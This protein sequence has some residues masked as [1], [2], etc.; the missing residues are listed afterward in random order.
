M[1]Y[2]RSQN[3]V[4]SKFRNVGFPSGRVRL[5]RRGHVEA[6]R[7]HSCKGLGY[8]MSSV[9]DQ[10]L[11]S[12]GLEETQA[13]TWTRVNS[14]PLPS[15]F[16]QTS[17]SSELGELSIAGHSAVGRTRCH[18]SLSQTSRSMMNKTILVLP[19]KRPQWMH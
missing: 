11:A 16:T 1:F 2:L 6:T 13:A 19:W 17:L 12:Q 10:K 15:P 3:P 9:P 8:P 18:V 14:G 5:L 7:A 4:V